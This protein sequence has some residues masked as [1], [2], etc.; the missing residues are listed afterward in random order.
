MRKLTQET[1]ID[2]EYSILVAVVVTNVEVNR[3]PCSPGVGN[4]V[5]TVTLREA[6]I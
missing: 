4:H 1:D 5:H 6:V 3:P 2:N